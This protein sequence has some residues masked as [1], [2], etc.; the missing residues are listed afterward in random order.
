MAIARS[1]AFEADLGLGKL[2]IEGALYITDPASTS[3]TRGNYSGLGNGEYEF[4]IPVPDEVCSPEIGLG[5]LQV[6]IC[7]RVEFTEQK[8]QGRV[9]TKNFPSGDW[10]DATWVDLGGW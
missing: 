3:Y 1:Y 2:K 6:K 9:R 10:S 7:L 4:P 5:P 8:F